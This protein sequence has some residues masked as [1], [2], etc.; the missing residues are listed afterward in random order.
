MHMTGFARTAR[1]CRDQ[2]LITGPTGSDVALH[3]A[4]GMP[5]E[6]GDAVLEVTRLFTGFHPTYLLDLALANGTAMTCFVDQNGARLGDEPESLPDEILAGLQHSLLGPDHPSARFHRPNGGVGLLDEQSLKDIIFVNTIP[7]VAGLCLYSGDAE[8]YCLRDAFDQ[9]IP[10]FAPGWRARFLFTGFAPLHVLELVHQDGRQACW[11]LSSNGVFFS[12]LIDFVP[13]SFRK[14][15][16]A[17][18]ARRF[19]EEGDPQQMLLRGFGLLNWRTRLDL[20]P[21]FPVVPVPPMRGSAAAG[22]LPVAM[23]GCSQGHSMG[24]ESQLMHPPSSQALVLVEQINP[25]TAG[26]DRDRLGAGWSFREHRCWATSQDNV[27][28]FAVPFAARMARLRVD[29]QPG[30]IRRQV[31]VTVNGWAIGESVI[32]P[33]RGEESRRDFWIP[34][35]AM[36]RGQL[37]CVLSFD[38]SDEHHACIVRGIRLDLGDPREQ[39]EL[40]DPRTLMTEFENIGDNCE[41]GLVQRYFGAEPLGLLRFADYGDFFN[42]IRLLENRFD[43]LGG[44]G[45]LSA[46]IVSSIARVEHGALETETEFYITDLQRRYSFHTWKGQSD[47]SELEALKEAEQKLSYLRRKMI[48]RLEQAS[49]IWLVKRTRHID[50]HEIFSLHAALKAYGPNRLFWVRSTKPGRPAGSVE[51]I[52]DDLLCGYSDQEHIHPHMFD[53]AAWL[54]LCENAHRAF[55]DKLP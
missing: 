12:H 16:A 41:F 51:W 39:A 48:E 23:Q 32:D 30:R 38:D 6:V 31:T 15:I 46:E 1:V 54:V 37:R 42:L 43:G 20:E 52:A 4:D 19:L 45:T 17:F 50:P 40:P 27:V 14:R 35:Q 49:R 34:A 55:A 3:H 29:F 28:L 18:G 44:A 7:S 26:F 36:Q 33:D 25:E 13:E 11:Y 53:P 47:Q 8:L 24:F 5:V 9:P 10:A 2:I 22:S 21:F